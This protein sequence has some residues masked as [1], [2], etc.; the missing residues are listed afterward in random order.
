MT[1]S[2]IR[3]TDIKV[4]Q[5]KH[6]QAVRQD[7][8]Y[9]RMTYPPTKGHASPVVTMPEAV[10]VYDRLLKRQKSEGYGKPEDYLFQPAHADNRSWITAVDKAV[11]S[12]LSITDL[13][14]NAN[15]ESRTISQLTSHLHHVQADKG[16]GIH[17]LLMARS[18]RTSA[19][20]IDRFYAK[21]LTA[22]MNIE[23]LQSLKPKKERKD[24]TSKP[25][26]KKGK[27]G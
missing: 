14:V 20:M 16:E 13:K 21:H 2:F 4:L 7:Q 24:V 22:E 15:G 25:A 18:A 9:L 6:V 26:A 1:N 19:E 23:L 10:K 11:R 27:G 5:H 8:T 17:P 3:P 12:A